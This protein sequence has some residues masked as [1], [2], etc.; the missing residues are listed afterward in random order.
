MYLCLVGYPAELTPFLLV[1]LG[2]HCYGCT[3]RGHADMKHP[4][5]SVEYVAGHLDACLPCRGS[6]RWSDSD[7]D[8][9]K[10]V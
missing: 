1:I 6:A 5:N 4:D 3:N 10:Y 2:Q 7:G 8:D 9:V